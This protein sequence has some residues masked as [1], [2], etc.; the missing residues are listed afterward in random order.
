MSLA[1]VNEGQLVMAKVNG[2]WMPCEVAC[3]S[4]DRARVTNVLHGI[5]T[6]RAVCDLKN[7]TGSLAARELMK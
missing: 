6:W 1:Y 7:P 3:A 2:A 5:D 4:G